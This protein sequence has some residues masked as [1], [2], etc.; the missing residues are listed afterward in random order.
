MK[1][2]TAARALLLCSLAF[3]A[4]AGSASAAGPPG[5]PGP[6]PGAGS[7]FPLPP[8]PGQAPAPQASQSATAIPTTAAGPGLLNGFAGL[9]GRTVRVNIACR[10]GGNASLSANGKLGQT[11]YRCS[12]GRSTVSFKLTKA[13]ASRVA[14]SGTTL[15]TVALT[16]GGATYRLS[17]SL[18]RTS[19]PQF[20]T[21]FLGL[22]CQAQGPDSA[23]LTAP[24]FQDVPA[25]TID[26]RPWL[27]WYTASTGWQWLG[28]R[29]T[30]RSA[31]YEW[32]AS[33][34]GVSEWQTPTGISPWTWGPIQV[35]PGH[36]T[37]VVSVMEAIYWYSHP[38]YVW[39]TVRAQPG[40]SP[41]DC[42]Y[43]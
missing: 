35:T 38:A 3:A 7:G 39:A 26:V 24:N 8:A 27:A 43:P 22:N 12:G 9:S 28:T 31:W 21:S 4:T 19:A 23:V 15:A 10:A 33:P 17:L 37:Y 14:H 1:L 41:T 13:S 20:W 16:T 34:I 29:G 36:G 11:K 30:G 18:G 6:P 42:V 25:T 32:T 5:P 40:S 2:R